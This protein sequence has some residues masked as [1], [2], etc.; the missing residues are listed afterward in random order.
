MTVSTVAP[1]GRA[2]QFA[3]DD[4]IVSKTDLK[5]RLTYT[6]QVFLDVSGFTEDELLGEPHNVI[7]HPWMP[8]CVFGLL[9]ERLLA[10]R[11]VFAYIANMCRN[12]DHYWVHAHVTPTVDARGAIVGFHSNRRVPRPEAVAAVEPLYR[13]LVAEEARHPVRREAVA[14]SRA[15]LDRKLAEAGLT[16]EEWVWQL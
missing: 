6:N 14:A 10:G 7:R 13:E 9:W 5:G 1:T 12:G 4:I 2:V 3:L 8:G 11:E 16:Y 15:M